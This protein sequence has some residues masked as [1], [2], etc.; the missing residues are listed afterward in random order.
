MADLKEWLGGFVSSYF[1][2]VSEVEE[3]L[4]GKNNRV[5]NTLEKQSVSSKSV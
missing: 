1:S 4:Q 5:P 2:G 3:Y